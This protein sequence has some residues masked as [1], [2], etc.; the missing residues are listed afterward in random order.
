MSEHKPFVM[1]RM[2][3]VFHCEAEAERDGNLIH[4]W[5]PLHYTEEL[6]ELD[7]PRWEDQQ[8]VFYR[9]GQKNWVHV[10]RHL[11][12]RWGGDNTVLILPS[13]PPGPC[14]GAVVEVTGAQVVWRGDRWFIRWHGYTNTR[15]A[16]MVA[17]GIE[18][19]RDPDKSMPL[20]SVQ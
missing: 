8:I 9:P 4:L 10:N 12:F 17:A 13:W 19:Y 3:S 14:A 15:P 6:T 2:L 1:S 18:W 16:R 11:M 7:K 20:R 5:E